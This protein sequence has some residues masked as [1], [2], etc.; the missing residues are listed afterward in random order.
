M[1]GVLRPGPADGDGCHDFRMASKASE[2]L[3]PFPP[4]DLGEFL[5]RVKQVRWDHY[6]MEIAL[7]VRKRANCLG[8]K[9]GAVL[10]VDNRIVSTG[11]NGTPAHFPNCMKGG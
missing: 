5:P 7:T 2:E 3:A 1:H 6:Y 11:F 9:I 10:V 8:A 4:V